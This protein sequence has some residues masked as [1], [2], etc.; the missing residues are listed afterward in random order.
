MMLCC[1]HHMTM[2]SRG[3]AFSKREDPLRPEDSLKNGDFL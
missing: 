2:F 1:A 3:L